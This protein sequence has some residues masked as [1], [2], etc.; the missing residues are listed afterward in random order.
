MPD[1]SLGARIAT[2][3]MRGLLVGTVAALAG[4]AGYW[5]ALYNLDC[6]PAPN[7]MPDGRRLALCVMP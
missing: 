4:T 6:M 3:I 1:A 7:A 2:A 5:L